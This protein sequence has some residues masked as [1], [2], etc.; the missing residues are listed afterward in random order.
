[1]KKMKA[2]KTAHT[3]NSKM[4][5][6]DNYGAAVKNKVGRVIESMDIKSISQKKSK[7]PPRSLA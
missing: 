6:A 2:L 7:T 1:M 3:S 4:G 5:T